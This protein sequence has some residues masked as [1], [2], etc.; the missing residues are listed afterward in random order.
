MQ[1]LLWR[2]NATCNPLLMYRF[3]CLRSWGLHTRLDCTQNGKKLTYRNPQ[4]LNMQSQVL[5]SPQ[6]RIQKN[7][8]RPA[9]LKN[10]NYHQKLMDHLYHIDR[11]FPYCFHFNFDGRLLALDWRSNKFGIIGSL[12]YFR[13]KDNLFADWFSDFFHKIKIKIF[14]AKVE[15]DGCL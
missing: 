3:N 10:K 11:R 4:M 15:S 5:C 9:H 12:F 8:Q 6:N 2:K 14:Q 7:W 13:R 1:N